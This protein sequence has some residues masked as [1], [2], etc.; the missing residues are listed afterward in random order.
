MA[1]M[2]DRCSLLEEEYVLGIHERL[3]EGKKRII[4]WVSRFE[5]SDWPIFAS[6]LDF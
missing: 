2:R 5:D 1:E 3:V 4:F 6:F